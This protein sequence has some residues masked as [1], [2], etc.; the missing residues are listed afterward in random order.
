MSDEATALCTLG[1]QL[2]EAGRLEEALET[3]LRVV[4]LCPD[5]P[6]AH[7]NLGN[8]YLKLN[9]LD[10]AAL[11]YREAIRR[12]PAYPEALSNLGLALA[13]VG[14]LDDATLLFSHAIAAAPAWPDAYHNLA[15]TLVDLGQTAEALAAY[16]QAVSLKPD[17]AEALA[18]LVHL[19]RHACDWDGLEAAEGALLDLVRRGQARI[20]PL[21]LMSL[22]GATPADHLAGARNWAAQF[23]VPTD[24]R[25]P[26]PP[27]PVAGRRIRLGYLS[28]DFHA[29]ATAYLTAE[30]FERHDRGRFE[31]FGYSFGP[32]DG[33][34]MRRRLEAGF[35]HFVD[36]R[37]LAHRDAAQRIRDDGIDLLIDLKGYTQNARPRILAYR[38]APIQ[39]NWLGYPGTMGAEFID[40][41]LVD[42]VV[43]PGADQRFYDERLISLPDCY[44][45]ND[46]QRPIALPPTRRACGLPERGVVFCCFN[47]SFK[48]TPV[49]FD[50][51]SRLLA[52]VPGSVLWLL[53]ANPLVEANLR[54]QALARGLDPD[55][56]VFAPRLP[57]A[58]HLAR[59]LVADLFLDVAPYNA[60]TT[61][62]DALWA[63][64][65]VLTLRGTTFAGRVAA[66]LLHAVGMPELVT[67]SLDEYEALAL[68]LARDPG[69]RATLRHRLEQGRTT[70]PL[71]DS[72]RFTAAIEAAFADLV[73]GRRIYTGGSMN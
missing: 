59:Y 66:S 60:H 47:N 67:N 68:A 39:I 65:P 24:S 37:A 11:A 51:W 73:A 52:Q 21:I 13:N 56:L 23:S 44:Q 45:P 49:F 6:E 55:R 25:L 18:A 72:R 27:P 33:S 46:S 2:Q 15:N 3:S 54:A 17:F 35:D 10:E 71:F 63:G 53:G 42:P 16:R 62:S 34:A 9:R 14:R 38:P 1:I 57:L 64:L 19:Q 61:A 28:A 40:A 58:E 50:A 22:T 30:L 31:V 69:R 7:N 41:V 48:L 32:D 43:A 26:P 8:V 70:A 5:W 20:A 12:R 29:H 4:E 36:L